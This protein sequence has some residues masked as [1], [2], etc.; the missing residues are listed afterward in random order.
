MT[1]AVCLF[2]RSARQCRPCHLPCV[3]GDML[4]IQL[5]LCQPNCIVLYHMVLRCIPQSDILLHDIVFVHCREEGCI[6]YVHC[7]EEGC[8]GLYIPDDQEI[9]RGPRDVPRAKP[10]GHLEGRGKSRGRRGCA[11]QYIPTRGSVRP[12]SHHLSIPR[13]VSGNTPL[14]GR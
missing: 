8:I 6:V 10:E 7:R 9:S 12:F 11:S 3:L 4:S 1:T 14:Q 2:H 5:I 13:D